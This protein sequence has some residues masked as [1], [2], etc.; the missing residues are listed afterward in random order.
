LPL[1]AIPPTQLSPS[2]LVLKRALDV[3]GSAIGLVLLSPVFAVIAIRIKL[4]SPGPV[5]FRQ[6]RPGVGGRR[7]RVV[8]FRTMHVTGPDDPAAPPLRETRLNDEY[9]RR[10]KL[11]NDPRVTPIGRWLRR[12]SIDELPQLWNVLRGEMSL[13]GPRPMLIEELEGR[14][15]DPSLRRTLRVKPGITGYWQINGRSDL[16]YDDR[17]R[18]ELSYVANWSLGLDL[19]IMMRTIQV[20]FSARGA[21]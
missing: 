18:L 4:G 8:K 10:F 1:I 16:D 5:F 6:E 3:V 2:A 11:A 15:H 17:V 12:T 14:W 7:F 20:L 19:T 21:V 13:V 9:R